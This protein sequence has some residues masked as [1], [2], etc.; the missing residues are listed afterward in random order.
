MNEFI[1]IEINGTQVY[2]GKTDD[3]HL[4]MTEYHYEADG[5]KEERV[6]DSKV[7]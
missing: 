6:F 1:R 5:T 3:M 7:D 4:I 2:N